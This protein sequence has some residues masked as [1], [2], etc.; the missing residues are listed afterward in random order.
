M[1]PAVTLPNSS[2]MA[3]SM[4][5]TSSSPTCRWSGSFAS[6]S[7][8]VIT[9]RR[10]VSGCSQIVFIRTPGCRSCHARSLIGMIWD[11]GVFVV[12]VILQDVASALPGLRG[13]CRELV[14]IDRNLDDGR[15]AHVERRLHRV[16]HLIG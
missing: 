6:G 4:T 10:L 2:E 7:M 3:P 5:K 13:R 15:L 16:S 14:R 9:A 12:I 11:S 1:F 8:R